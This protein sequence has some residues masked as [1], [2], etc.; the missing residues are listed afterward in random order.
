M[1][2][3]QVGDHIRVAARLK[4][5]SIYDMVNVWDINVVVVPSPTTEAALDEDIQSMMDE[6]YSIAEGAISNRV[7]AWDIVITN[8]TAGDPSRTVLWVGGFAGGT[9]TSEALPPANAALILLRTAVTGVQ[10]KKYL[11]VGTES[12]QSAGVWN[13]GT[14]TILTNMCAAIM[15][16]WSGTNG[17]EYV[18]QVYSPTLDTM[19]PLTS[20]IG[21][22]AVAYQR[23]RRFGRG[24]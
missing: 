6:F 11:P 7:V 14:I 5:D 18:V 12:L 4:F 2:V 20:A 9:S 1:T 22:P 15:G 21:S 23:R 3:P 19:N 10:G 24:S 16:Q 17:G 13:A 8:V